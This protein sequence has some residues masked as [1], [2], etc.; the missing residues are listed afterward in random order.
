MAAE[1]P[2]QSPREPEAQPE[3]LSKS[4]RLLFAFVLA[5]IAAMFGVLAR[6]LAA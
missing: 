2:Y 3:R 4:E 1:N 6:R 5:L